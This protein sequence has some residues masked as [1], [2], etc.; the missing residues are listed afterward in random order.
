MDVTYLLLLLLSAE[1][2]AG[3]AREPNEI[4]EN[5]GIKLHE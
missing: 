4:N 3:G 1:S 2:A 5:N